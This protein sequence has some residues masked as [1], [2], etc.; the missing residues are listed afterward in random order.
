MIG[1]SIINWA[2][3]WDP[4]RRFYLINALSIFMENIHV[5]TNSHCASARTIGGANL[6]THPN[7]AQTE[8]PPMVTGSKLWHSSEWTR[9]LDGGLIFLFFF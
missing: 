4:P 3:M 5:R 9:P 1:L 8:T 7:H 6:E 2:N